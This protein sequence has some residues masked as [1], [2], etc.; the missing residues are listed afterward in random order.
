VITGSLAEGAGFSA[1][2]VVSG[3]GVQAASVRQNPRQNKL[4]K[5][6]FTTVLM[7]EHSFCFSMSGPLSYHALRS[8][9]NDKPAA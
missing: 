3:E 8:S 7:A 2:G 1:G 6:R 5:K 4:V 9:V